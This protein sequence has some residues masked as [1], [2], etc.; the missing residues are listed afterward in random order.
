MEDWKT[1]D[2]LPSNHT[3]IIVIYALP[4]EQDYSMC[5]YHWDGRWRPD[6]VDEDDKGTYPVLW[7]EAPKYP[8]L[9]KIY[10]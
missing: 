3:N 4:E 8:K 2:T 1:F 7:M 5:L 10:G 6:A 9:P